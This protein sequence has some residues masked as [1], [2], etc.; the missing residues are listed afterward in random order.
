MYIEGGSIVQ[1]AALSPL[2]TW[3]NFYVIT[4]SAAATLTGLMFVVI[5]LIV[6]TRARGSSVWGGIAAF[7][8]QTV[9]HFCAALLITALFRVPW[10][11]IWI[12]V[13]R[14]CLWG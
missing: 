6:G 14:A 9:V 3:Q 2:A 10:L 8:M 1:E 7:C 12:Y 13:L 5:S 11:A 4:G